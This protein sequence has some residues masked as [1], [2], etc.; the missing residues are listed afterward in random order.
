MP[1][2]G[3]NG[4][5]W[6]LESLERRVSELEKNLNTML[7]ALARI[8]ERGT[9]L[10]QEVKAAREEMNGVRRA[11]YTFGFGFLLVA[12]TGI[13]SIAVLLAQ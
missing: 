7:G 12:A 4:I 5:R 9:A 3:G 8:E 13:G 2:Q 1:D 6:R 10:S 11:L